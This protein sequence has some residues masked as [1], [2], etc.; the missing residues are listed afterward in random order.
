MQTSGKKDF[1]SFIIVTV[2]VMFSGLINFTQEM[3]SSK[4]NVKFNLY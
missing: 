4:A 1:T 3:K 2:M